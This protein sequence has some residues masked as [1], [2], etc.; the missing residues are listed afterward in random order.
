MRICGLTPPIQKVFEITRFDKT[1]DIHAGENSTRASSVS[2]K[3]Y[4]R[5]TA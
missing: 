5:H 1:F 4:S 2:Q 3:T